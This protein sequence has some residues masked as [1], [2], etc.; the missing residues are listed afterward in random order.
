MK[1]D[2]YFSKQY[3]ALNPT[4]KTIICNGV[5]AKGAWYNFLIPGKKV[6]EEPANGHDCDYHFGK[7]QADKEISDRRFNQNCKRIVEATKNPILKK[8]RKILA[9]SY[10]IAVRDFGDDAYWK[11]KIIDPKNS[12]KKQV[13]I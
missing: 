1:V 11:D 7:T 12:N 4:Q 10:F 3:L 13:E 9:R 2:L 5:G 8:S 6:F